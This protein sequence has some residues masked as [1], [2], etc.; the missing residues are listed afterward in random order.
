MTNEIL[1][2]FI[3]LAITGTCTAIALHRAVVRD[4]RA[5][6]L[7]GLFYAT[8]FMGDLYWSLML[9][10]YGDTPSY[11]YVSEIGWYSSFLFLDLLLRQLSSDEETEYRPKALWAAPVFTAAMAVFY[12]QYGDYVSNT[13]VAVLMG[14][15]LWRSI[16]GL[17]YINAG[18]GT[19]ADAMRRPLYLCVLGFCL[20]EYCEWTASCFMSKEDVM[21]LYL[22]FDAAITLILMLHIPALG[23]AVQK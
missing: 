9:A 14:A 5:W 4:S 17:V 3:Q 21:M 7:L 10:F 20:I 16:R 23:K 11:F 13:V 15:L 19:S 18:H 2:N 22:A 8:F 6:V 12:M 1:V